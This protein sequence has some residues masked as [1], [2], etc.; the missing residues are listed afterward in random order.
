MLLRI[1]VEH[2]YRTFTLAATFEAPAEGITVL[3]G[4]SGSGKTTVLAAVAGLIRTDGVRIDLAGEALDRLLAPGGRVGL[5]SI[6]MPHDRMLATLSGHT[7]IHKYIF[8]GGQIPSLE[9]IRAALD[10]HTGLRIGADFPMGDHY[11]RTLDEWRTRFLAAAEEVGRLGF[12]PVFRR[13]WDLYLAYSEAGFRSGYLD[14]HQLLL[15]RP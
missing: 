15:Q 10:E 4:P 3:F 12:D 13:M 8:P 5:Q 2:S 9:A 14:V 1:T 6:T 7:W 11:A